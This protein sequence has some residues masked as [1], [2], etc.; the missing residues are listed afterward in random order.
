MKKKFSL[1]VKKS[2]EGYFKK[3]FF[4]KSNVINYKSIYI[5]TYWT[6]PT[7]E[8][9]ERLG[10]EVFPLPLF[11]SE[12][13]LATITRWR[14]SPPRTPKGP[15]HLITLPECHWLILLLDY[16]KIKSLLII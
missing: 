8:G 9:L 2:V 10:V 16:L 3:I 4:Y 14:E 13:V 7:I 15:A 12:K 5:A 11:I 1:N 6:K